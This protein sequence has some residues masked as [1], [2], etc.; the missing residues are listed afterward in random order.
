MQVEQPSP[1]SRHNAIPPIPE[2][3]PVFP[4]PNVVLFPGAYVPLHV[5]EPRYREMVAD[6]MA[7]S[8]C[9]GL[10]LLKDGWEEQYYGNPPVYDIGCVGRM[11]N[12]KPLPD[13]R[14]DLL[15]LGLERYE[16]REQLYERRYR[17]ARIGVRCTSA[18]DG[19]D[20]PL[21]AELHRRLGE[22]LEQ[23]DDEAPWRELLRLEIP[24]DILVNNLSM[25]LDLTPVERQFLL[26]A[27]TI[28]Q[29]ARRLSDLIEFKQHERKDARGLG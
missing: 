20:A 22:H 26:E 11:V 4:L 21:R 29:R 19:L 5:F 16:I 15:L 14:Y 24:D 9:I 2:I 6:A 25:S 13:G 17:Q 8:Q 3:I 1:R 23:V 18:A 7:G 28:V 12:V 27:D 10:A